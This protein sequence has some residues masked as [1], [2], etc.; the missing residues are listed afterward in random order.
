MDGL[1]DQRN[2]ASWWWRASLNTSCWGYYITR[3]I[4]T[5]YCVN[6]IA[7]YISYTHLQLSPLGNL[8]KYN[9]EKSTSSAV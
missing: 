8:Y 9:K 3:K 6:I 4:K 5:Q 2:L 7:P 1:I